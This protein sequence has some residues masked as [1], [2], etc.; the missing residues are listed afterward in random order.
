MSHGLS[1]RLRLSLS[2]NTA[3][4]IKL[5]EKAGRVKVDSK[6]PGFGILGLELQ[7]A[8]YHPEGQR[9]AWALRA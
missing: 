5:R 9:G 6:P 8:S 7:A 2:R 1:R 4:G 3:K